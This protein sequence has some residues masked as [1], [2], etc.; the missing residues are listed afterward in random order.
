[1]NTKN[2][3]DNA[4]KKAFEDYQVPLREAQWQRIEGAVAKNKTGKKYLILVAVLLI[5]ASSVLTYILTMHFSNKEPKISHEQVSASEIL[6]N[7]KTNILKD[8]PDQ[9]NES[10]NL[11]KNDSNAAIEDQEKISPEVS[12][13]NN[14]Y[15]ADPDSKMTKVEDKTENQK[16]LL[17]SPSV[18]GISISNLFDKDPSILSMGPEQIQ[19]TTGSM[20][21]NKPAFKKEN[22]VKSPKDSKIVLSAAAGY[23]NLRMNV[24]NIENQNM[25]HKDTRKI[26]E[27]TNKNLKTTFFN[28]GADFSILPGLNIGLNTGLQYVKIASPVNTSYTMNEVPFYDINR[29]II[30]YYNVDSTN[31]TEFN[32]NQTNTTSFINI[33]L[34]LNYVLPINLKS[35]L[36]IT[37]GANFAAISQASGKTISLSRSEIRELSQ[38]DFNKFSMGFLGGLQYSHKLVD[39]WW[40]GFESQI[41]SNTIKYQSGPGSINASLSG[42]KLNLILKYK[43]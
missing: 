30:G 1:M 24:I 21:L 16:S 40:L 18:T 28:L 42:Y 13:N 3:L 35:E 10:N 39:N 29:T 9:I 26:F 11:K 37:A 17:A 32:L 25:L 27:E 43:L 41:L 2:N 34:R 8:I 12:G 38:S 33:P 19:E 20:N 31:A 14:R 6:K 22:E 4:F 15:V 5:S 36:L 7:N 23:S